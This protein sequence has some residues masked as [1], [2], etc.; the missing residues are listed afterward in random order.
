MD[1]SLALAQNILHVPYNTNIKAEELI[2]ELGMGLSSKKLKKAMAH[3]D[4]EG[5]DV[6]WKEDFLKWFAENG[7]V[8]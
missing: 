1:R 2:E 8:E 5:E 6:I 4:P 3:I 7:Q